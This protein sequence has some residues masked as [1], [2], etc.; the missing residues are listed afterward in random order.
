MVYSIIYNNPVTGSIEEL[1]LYSMALGPR[2]YPSLFARA[3]LLVRGEGCFGIEWGGRQKAG[4]VLWL[5]G[6]GWL[7][8]GGVGWHYGNIMIKA[9]FFFPFFWAVG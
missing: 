9:F 5:G 7:A 3:S 4:S 6:C 2:V 8:G 1:G